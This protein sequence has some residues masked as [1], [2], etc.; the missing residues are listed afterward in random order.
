M[1][2]ISSPGAQSPTWFYF[3]GGVVPSRNASL[4]L[5]P[6]ELFL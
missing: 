6:P 2:N 4:G 5:L 1:L 3:E